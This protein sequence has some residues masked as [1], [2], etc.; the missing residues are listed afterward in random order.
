MSRYEQLFANLDKQHQGAFVPF[1]TLGDPTPEVSVEVIKRLID[2]G[3][4]GDIYRVLWQWLEARAEAYYERD[5]WRCTWEH[6]GGGVLMNQTSHDIDL[7]CWM[8]GE[9]VEVSAMISNWGHRAEI[10]DTA[11][12]NVRF[13]SGAVCN[14]QLS[15]CDR[16]LNYRQISGNKGTVIYQDEKNANSQVPDTFRLGR[17]GSWVSVETAIRRPFPNVTPLVRSSGS[18]VDWTMGENSW[19]RA[20]NAA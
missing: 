4:L 12:A 5:I 18:H 9:P 7:L 8:M 2:A 6:A 15:I 11:I 16:R 20:A 3:E 10:E 1:V 14:L 19:C 13:A 17:Y